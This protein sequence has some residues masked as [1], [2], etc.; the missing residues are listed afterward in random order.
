[1]KRA[2][3]TATISHATSTKVEKKVILAYDAA[4]VRDY[5]SRQGYTVLEVRKGDF[6]KME[7]VQELRSQ[8]RPGTPNVARIREVARALGL[9]LPVEIKV[10]NGQN[11][12]LGGWTAANDCKTRIQQQTTPATHMRHQIA[13]KGW[14]PAERM[15]EV[16]MH[17]LEHARQFEREV[18]PNAS[19]V[20]DAIMGIRRIYNNGVSYNAKRWEREARAAEATA[21]NYPGIV[22]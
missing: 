1:M 7:A 5:Y 4:G 14:L 19:T 12:H 22:R 6:R 13:L 17:E 10:R 18:L 9:T 2:R 3:Y 21:G 8:G 20:F 11:L 16:I 15:A